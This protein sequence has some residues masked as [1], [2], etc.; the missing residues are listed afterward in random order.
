MSE[1]A[2]YRYVAKWTKLS[3]K[4]VKIAMERFLATAVAEL[5]KTGSVK[6]RDLLSMNLRCKHGH[7]NTKTV[8]I[9]IVGKTKKAMLKDVHVMDLSH[10]WL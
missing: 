7:R 4:T 1:S 2:A 5:N 3:A 9:R 6:L 8:S 10:L